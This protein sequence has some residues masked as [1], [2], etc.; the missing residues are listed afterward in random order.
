MFHTSSHFFGIWIV[1]A[2]LKWR[3]LRFN[4]DIWLVVNTPLCPFSSSEESN[5][6]LHLDNKIELCIREKVI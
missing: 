1:V 2:A 4:V 6:F 5:L 3:L